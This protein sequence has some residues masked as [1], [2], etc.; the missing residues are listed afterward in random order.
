MIII[1][2]I[3]NYIFEGNDR[4]FFVAEVNQLGSK[5]FWSGLPTCW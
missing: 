3:N 1:I 4:S 5:M 2:I